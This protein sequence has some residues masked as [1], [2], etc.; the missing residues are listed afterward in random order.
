MNEQLD[1]LVV[2]DG[3]SFVSDL[4]EKGLKVVTTTETHRLT[5]GSVSPDYDAWGYLCGKQLLKENRRNIVFLH[6]EEP[7]NAP[8]NGFRRAFREAG[9]PLNEKFFLKDYRS[10]LTE[11]KNM[12]HY[13]VQIDAV[14]DTLW[15]NNEVAE[16]LM[17]DNP[18]LV[19]TCALVHNAFSAPQNSGFHEICYEIPFEQIAEETAELLRLQFAGDKAG[20]D[21]RKIPMKMIIK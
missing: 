7:W 12:V 17:A 3:N 1:A 11:L 19:K 14:V 4:R 5:P 9:V 8:Y 18:E 10:S 13:G 15:V 20:M 2:V 21:I 6:D 16:I